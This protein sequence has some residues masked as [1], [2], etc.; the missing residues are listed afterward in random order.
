MTGLAIISFIRIVI[1]SSTEEGMSSQANYS[2]ILY[3]EINHS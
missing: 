1:L 2:E 3:S